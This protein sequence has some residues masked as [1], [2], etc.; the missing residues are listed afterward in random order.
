[1]SPRWTIAVAACACAAAGAYAYSVDPAT[2]GYPGCLLYQATGYYCAGCGATRAIHALLHGRVLDALHDNLF[3]TL[4]LPLVA[5][6]IFRFAAQAWRES[7][8][9]TIRAGQR[10]IAWRGAA[11]VGVALLFMVVRN[12]PGGAFDWLRPLA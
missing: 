5:A 11:M 3:F 8:W 2:G 1:M 7:E 4:L 10:T 9:P 12:V 6:M